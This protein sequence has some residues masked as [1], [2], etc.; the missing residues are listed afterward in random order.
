MKKEVNKK[1]H[2]AILK[3]I[4]LA[5]GQSALARRCGHGV[6]QQQVY[7]WSVRQKKVSSEYVIIVEQGIKDLPG[8]PNRHDLRPDIYPLEEEE[9]K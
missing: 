6:K 4:E 3:A 8:A 5:G 1:C 9:R 7:N 2:A